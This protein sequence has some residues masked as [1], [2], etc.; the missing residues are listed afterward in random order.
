MGLTTADSSAEP[1]EEADDSSDRD[2]SSATTSDDCTTHSSS[3]AP[4]SESG[5][6]DEW[7]GDLGELKL[8]FSGVMEAFNEMKAGTDDRVAK[9]QQT[10][11]VTEILPLQ[12]E[13]TIALTLEAFKAI[14]AKFRDVRPGSES[15]VFDMAN[16]IGG[17]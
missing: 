15:H 3:V 14:G 17:S 12:D 16:L 5:G 10:R 1:P 7:H 2:T 9:L 4:T 8:S 6:K 11:Y 13:L